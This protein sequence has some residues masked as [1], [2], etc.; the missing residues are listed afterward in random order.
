MLLLLLLLLKAAGFSGCA[1]QT[2]AGHVTTT[3]LR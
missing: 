3:S 1:D 2:E